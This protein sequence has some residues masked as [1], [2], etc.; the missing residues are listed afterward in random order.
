MPLP[1]T[2]S[3]RDSRPKASPFP[4]FPCS[5]SLLFKQELTAYLGHPL[6]FKGLNEIT[7][8][9]SA[10][11]KRA[12]HPLV[13]VVAPEQDVSSGVIQ[14]VVNEFRVGEVRV[15]GNRWFSDNIVSAPIT[16]QHGDTIDT[17]LLLGEVDA[18]NANP[19]RRV[20]LD[21][22]TVQPSPAI[23]ISF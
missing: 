4:P 12:N 16:L 15:Q 20:D 2:S 19:F 13:D 9:V 1:R 11:Y 21:L 8:K 10:F 14:I 17:Q 5:T 6:T 23:P 18:A 3:K 7:A 22:P